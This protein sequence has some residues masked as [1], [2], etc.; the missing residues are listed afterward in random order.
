MIMLLLAACTAAR[1]SAAAPRGAIA[2][3]LMVEGGPPPLGRAG[4]QP[5]IRIR[6]IPGTVQFIS[7][8]HQRFTV[9]VNASGRFSV[10]LPAGR[11]EVS[12]RSPDLLEVG[13]SGTGRQTWSSPVPVV[14]TGHHTTKVPLTMIVP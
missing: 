12:W 14:V 7:S 6:P 2:G 10:Q 8:Q 11:Y 5:G 4:Q 9:R 3:R 1:A 13:A